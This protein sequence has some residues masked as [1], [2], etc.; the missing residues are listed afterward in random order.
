MLSI[1]ASSAAEATAQDR[2][3]RP[4]LREAPRRLAS[5]VPAITGLR[6]PA[7]GGP[8]VLL[9]IS[10]SGL[11]AECSERLQL[12]CRVTVLVE[13][14]F[15]TKSIR[16]KV[17]RSAVAKLGADGRLRYHVGVQFDAPITLD[18]ESA[19]TTEVTAI[20]SEAPGPPPVEQV[21]VTSPGA[22]VSAAPATVVVEPALI[23][24][25]VEPKRRNRW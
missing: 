11:L 25:P 4:E 14:T 19:V 20:G 22:I 16:G 23:D 3:G 1:A 13:G 12:G 17:A 5:A 24:P 10:A 15:A 18:Q 8:A 9:N 6:F 21:A 7:N 2:G